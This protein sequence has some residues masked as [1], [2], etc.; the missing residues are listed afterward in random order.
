M[1]CRAPRCASGTRGDPDSRAHPRAL[2]LHPQRG[3][4]YASVKRYSC[5]GRLKEVLVDEGDTV[6][7]GQVVAT[8]DTQPL[9]AQLRNAQAQIR[10]AEDNRRSANAQVKVKQAEV[11]Y[12]QKEYKRSK[13]LIKSG[14]VSQ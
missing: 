8:I 9:E 3:A 14:A 2:A 6:D 7:A 4:P 13:A 10:E 11:D 5:A 1:P 12:A